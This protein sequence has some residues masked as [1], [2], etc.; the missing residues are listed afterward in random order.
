MWET[1]ICKIW[2]AEK[3]RDNGSK[4]KAWNYK[5]KDLLFSQGF[6]SS[7]KMGI[8]ASWQKW[9]TIFQGLW[10]IESFPWESSMKNIETN[11]W[12][13]VNAW[14]IGLHSHHWPNLAFGSNNVDN[15]YAFLFI[16]QSLI[17]N[18]FLLNDYTTLI[19]AEK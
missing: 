16:N 9:G 18:M 2:I 5:T 8:Q 3:N 17:Y 19:C 12:V 6:V 7:F 4:W 11:A 13:G 14:K 1:I 15:M 10:C